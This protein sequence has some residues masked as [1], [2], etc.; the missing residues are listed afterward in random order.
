LVLKSSRSRFAVPGFTFVHT[1]IVILT[2]IWVRL[3]LAALALHLSILPTSTAAI[4]SLITNLNVV[5]LLGSIRRWE[6][7]S[8][9]ARTPRNCL[10]AALENLSHFSS[11]VSMSTQP[12][13]LPD[14]SLV[15]LFTDIAS[16]IEM[17]FSADGGQTF[18]LARLV[19][20]FARYDEPIARAPGFLP[21][22]T[23]DRQAGILYV[24]YQALLGSG[25]QARPAILFTRSIDR[26]K[27]WS[28]P[29]APGRSN[30]SQQMK[31]KR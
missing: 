27:S 3:V 17:V 16:R 1:R 26:G 24:T 10:T 19:T 21:S 15:V 28:T 8:A 23:T 25:A 30:R 9:W 4:S 20:T 5:Q 31:G 18:G 29:V 22:A 11:A 12:L 13:F 7:I 2:S 6:R 14:G